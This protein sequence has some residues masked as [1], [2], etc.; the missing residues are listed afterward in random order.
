M[1]NFI[2]ETPFFIGNIYTLILIFKISAL[3]NALIK[4]MIAGPRNKPT[5]P[6]S[7]KQMY[8]LASA[9]NAPIPMAS[10]K[11]LG[12]IMRLN[13]NNIPYK[14]SKLIAIK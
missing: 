10:P 9:D 6:T 2:F 5:I 14:T 4:M 11:I 12:S 3:I 8:M 7:L 13:A 1:N